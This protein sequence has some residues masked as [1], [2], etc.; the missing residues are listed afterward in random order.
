MP[1]SAPNPF[2]RLREPCYVFASNN[3]WGKQLAGRLPSAPDDYR[4]LLR[5]DNPLQFRLCFSRT[6]PARSILRQ[7]ATEAQYLEYS[8][9]GRTGLSST[10]YNK[11]RWFLPR[12]DDFED[13]KPFGFYI[14][15][16]LYRQRQSR[17][18]LIVVAG[19]VQDRQTFRTIRIS[20]LTDNLTLRFVRSNYRKNTPA[21]VDFMLRP[22]PSNPERLY[23]GLSE[24][25]SI[26]EDP[27]AP[28]VVIIDGAAFPNP[29]RYANR[30]LIPFSDG[31]LSRSGEWVIE[32]ARERSV[33]YDGYSF[34]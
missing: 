9:Q 8:A 27:N 24:Y 34:L 32:T 7:A 18:E 12:F 33:V 29:R 4:A 6:T 30:R 16:V 1:N 26:R 22:H 2:F 31:Y 28:P 25:S 11:F 3:N 15:A 14:G 20:H 21:A 19:S 17:D 5:A 13:A 10:E 23:L